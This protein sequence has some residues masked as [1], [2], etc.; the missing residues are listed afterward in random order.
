[1]K[2]NVMLLVTRLN[3]KITDITPIEDMY[4]NCQITL[5]SEFFSRI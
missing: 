5:S 2:Y 3:G 1:M 4:I